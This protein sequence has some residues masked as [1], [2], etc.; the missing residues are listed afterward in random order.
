[1]ANIMSPTTTKTPSWFAPM[2]WVEKAGTATKADVCSAISAV[3]PDIH[4]FASLISPA[5]DSMLEEMAAKAQA[6]TQR[7]FGRTISLYAPLYLSSYCNGG[8]AYCGFAA[9]R[10]QPRSKLSRAEIESELDA[11][12]EMGIRDVL[13]LTGERSPEADV[14]YIADAVSIAASRFPSVSIETFAMEQEEYAR[15]VELGCTGVTLYQETYHHETY[16]AMHR[17]GDK[18]DYSARMNA[19]DRLL[20]A[21]IRKFGMGALFGLAD[22]IHD[23]IALFQHA[24]YL[25]KRYWRSGIS[26]SFPRICPESGSFESGHPISDSML[27]KFILAFRICLPDVPL[28]LSTRESRA[29]R[30]A[31][32]GLGINRMSVASR[33]TVGGYSH[34]DESQSSRQF[35]IDDDR[36]VGAF[37]KMLCEKG[38]EPVFKNWDAVYR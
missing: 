8:C 1:M 15:L 34:E 21:G 4:A 7:H 20:S 24:R 6:L 17:W 3:R 19:P 26:L 32:A 9:D 14:D 38:L 31:M 33:T 5:A 11:L 12:Y 35:S 2:P 18:A 30:D 27:V 28:V 10:K 29:F 23:A 22:P 16:G 36:D 25:Q 13:L 37:C